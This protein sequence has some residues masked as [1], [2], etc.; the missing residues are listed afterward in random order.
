MEDLLLGMAGLLDPLGECVMVA[1]RFERQSLRAIIGS[2]PHVADIVHNILEIGE[3]SVQHSQIKKSVNFPG[4]R[5]AAHQTP[6]HCKW[7]LA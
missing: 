3:S 5:S 7:S 1:A 6:W 2:F 4:C